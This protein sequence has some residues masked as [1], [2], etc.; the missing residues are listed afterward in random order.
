MRDE[1]GIA[2]AGGQGDQM[3]GKVVRICHMGAITKKDIE[4]GLKVLGQTLKEMKAPA[5]SSCC[6]CK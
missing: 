3:K 5:G 4:N 6:C 1:K 2:M